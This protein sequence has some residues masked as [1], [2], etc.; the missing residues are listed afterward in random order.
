MSKTPDGGHH[1]LKVQQ[2]LAGAEEVRWAHQPVVD[3]DSGAIVGYEALVRFASEQRSPLPWLQAAGQLGRRSELEALLLQQVLD[4][5]QEAP[6]GAFLAVNLSPRL[7][8][9]GPVWRALSDAGD[10]TG[11]VIELTEHEQVDNL[12]LLRSKLDAI[13]GSG[14]TIALDDV[15]A[16]W[17]GLRQVVELRPDILKIDQSI[18]S[19]LHEDSARS[20]VVELLSTLTERLGGSLLAEGIEH[21]DE[22]SALLRLDVHL[23][24]GYLC[25]RP[26]FGWPSRSPEVDA[27]L[28]GSSR[29]DRQIGSLAQT[30]PP[31]EA[32]AADGS[33]APSRLAVIAYQAQ[34]RGSRVRNK[35]A[36]AP[37]GWPR[38]ITAV[39]AT[40][41]VR[42][43]ACRAMERPAE[44]RLDPL[45]CLDE[46]G[47]VHGVVTVDHL[48]SALAGCPGM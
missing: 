39:P 8:L 14:A 16:G 29:S 48:M 1:H 10:L 21:L 2:V 40:A 30:V 26:A 36:E 17:S 38:P 11:L 31:A 47:Q 23:G 5:R 25:G 34:M 9:D 18:V 20:S 24:Q 13:R 3:L 32:V 45:V 43:A 46:T 35:S 19:R 27:A 15:G 4:A 44:E 6:S 42:G 22:L 33:L 41:T 37:S 7:L 12:S 28:A